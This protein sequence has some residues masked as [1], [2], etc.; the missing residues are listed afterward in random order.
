MAGG[1]A[2]IGVIA[3]FVWK[4]TRKRPAD[5]DDGEYHLNFSF[6]H[7]IR[8][9]RYAFSVHFALVGTWKSYLEK[10]PPCRYSP[11]RADIVPDCAGLRSNTI[12]YSVEPRIAL[13]LHICV[14]ERSPAIF[15]AFFCVLVYNC[16]FVVDTLLTF[17]A[18][19]NLSNG[20]S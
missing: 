18:Q 4:F 9:G 13:S 10:L 11:S 5:Y 14:G 3:F 7:S 16:I 6:D 15:F 19:Q 12:Q 1:V 8:A 20:L 17:S 2:L